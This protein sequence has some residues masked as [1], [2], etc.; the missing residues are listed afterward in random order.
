MSFKLKGSASPT[1]SG[2]SSEENVVPPLARESPILLTA[3][4][5]TEHPLS[6]AARASDNTNERCLEPFQ[7]FVDC[8]LVREFNSSLP[9][10]PPEFESCAKGTF[11]RRMLSS[12]LENVPRC[13]DATGRSRYRQ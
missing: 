13:H 4:F 7:R 6:A 5:L 1:R 3:I 11:I 2:S 12:I 9:L 10:F 8:A